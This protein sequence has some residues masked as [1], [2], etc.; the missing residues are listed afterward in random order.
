MVQFNPESLS[1]EQITSI[2]QSILEALTSPTNDFKVDT[3]LVQASQY[4][5][6]MLSYI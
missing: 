3:L 1:E 2:E 6:L 5:S 4:A